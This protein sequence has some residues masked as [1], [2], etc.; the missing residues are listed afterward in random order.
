LNY[1]IFVLRQ[2]F[3]KTGRHDIT[4]I[5]LEVAINTITLT[6]YPIENKLYFINIRD[7]I[8]DTMVRLVGGT[9]PS[10]GRIE[11]FHNGIWGTICDKTF[12]Q[13]AATVVCTMLG[14]NNS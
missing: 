13:T 7:Y 2:Y 6:S 3:S 14:Y 8:L 10:N 9:K 5:L 1:A 11:I 12:S 4:E